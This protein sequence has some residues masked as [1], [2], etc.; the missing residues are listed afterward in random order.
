MILM[1]NADDRDSGPKHKVEEDEEVVSDAKTISTCKIPTA[2]DI[3]IC[4]STV[5]GKL[6]IMFPSCKLFSQ[7]YVS[8]RNPKSGSWFGTALSQALMKHSHD[9]ELHHLLTL[10]RLFGRPFETH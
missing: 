7:G 10:V 2:N 8:W 5:N 3:M 1:L 6:T 4:Y 9:K